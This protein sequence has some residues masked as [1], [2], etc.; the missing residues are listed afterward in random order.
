MTTRSFRKARVPLIS[1]AQ[2]ARLNEYFAQ[3][4]NAMPHTLATSTQIGYSTAYALLIA[5][6]TDG[7]ASLFWMIFHKCEPHPVADRRFEEGPITS[8]WSCPECENE[9][10]PACLSYAIEGRTST[11]VVF[12]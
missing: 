9:V 11:P 10:E 8:R 1:E 4:R 2:W 6:A 7:A 5:M 12:E 3:P